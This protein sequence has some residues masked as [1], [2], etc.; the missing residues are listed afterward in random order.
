M[1]YARIQTTDN[2]SP[3]SF[4]LT[5]VISGHPGFAGLF[6]LS[7]QDQAGVLLTIWKSREDAELAS[8]RTRA[9]AGP[10]PITL[11]SDDVYEVDSDLAGR[12]TAAV[13]LVGWFDG[14]LS[15]ERI[16]AA[17]NRGRDVIH[18]ALRS[19]PGRVRSF[20]LWQPEEQ[21][22]VVVHL[23]ESAE[24]LDTIGDTVRSLPVGPDEDPALLTGPDRTSQYRVVVAALGESF[25]E[26]A[27]SG[28]HR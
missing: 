27:S 25:S 28:R 18:P 5:D 14:P 13:A 24:V 17:R 2:R 11:T 23:A 10:R 22:F 4:S 7:G 3:G 19:L 26:G 20:V 1:T 8:D 21:G 15:P 12:G 6:L 16:A 9:A